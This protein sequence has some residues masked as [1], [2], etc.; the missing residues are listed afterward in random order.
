MFRDNQGHHQP[1][2]WIDW[3]FLPDEVLKWLEESWA[4]VFYREFFCRLDERPFAV[5]Y[6]SEPSRPNVPVNVLVSLEALKA[7]FGW[8]DA[9]MYAAFFFDL[10]V[11]YAVGFRN[12]SDGYFDLRTVYNFR[13][14]LC[15][16]MEAT[17]EDLMSK[18]FEGI[19]DQQIESFQLKTGKLRMDSTQIASNIRQMSRLQLLVE[20]VQRVY[21]MLTEA[22][23][24]RYA[25]QFA[26]YLKGSSGQYIYRIK[27]EET[28]PHLERIGELMAGCLTE[29]ASTYRDHPT[30]RILE[31]VFGEQFTVVEAEVR[32]KAGKE[33]SPS[34][35]QSPD[36]PDASY[37]TKGHRHYKGYVTNVSETC[38]PDNPFQLV[39]GVQTAPNTTE[40]ATM[41]VQAL[42][43]LK[44]RT[45]VDTMYSDASY[46]SPEV[47]E[48]LREQGVEQVP[49]AVKGVEK[50]PEA[51]HL[52]DFQFLENSHGEVIVITCPNGQT[53][54]VEI[55]QKPG[56][57]I[58]HFGA[59]QCAACP[60]QECCP[61]Q[62][63]KRDGG[64]TL[65]F[66][67]KQA[68][69]AQR[70]QRCE[71]HRKGGK[72]LR[73]AI[74]AVMGA[75]KRP[76]SDDQL[77]VRG[78]FRVSM[79]MIGSAA[80]V[81]VRRIQRHLAVEVRPI[82]AERAVRGAK[83]AKEA[84]ISLLSALLSHHFQHPR[85]RSLSCQAA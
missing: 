11:R 69:I 14:R 9:E 33:I 15:Q 81:N 45:G 68:D 12:L 27:G 65:K 48:V 67:E 28:G 61:T 84:A 43:E 35:L 50:D 10:Q 83:G 74:E 53:V 63:K 26:P 40:D 7:S 30:Y 47:D 29:L 70:R 52:D 23:R 8:S 75:I 78:L 22:D 6:S 77:P 24:E 80:M 3:G 54:P 73:V 46:C 18:A 13:R 76:F 82:G 44:E 60:F 41:L 42:P 64:R 25:E 51:L 5:L 39:T 19:T 31:R 1:P 34:S 72:N 56:R 55:G 58:A 36:D 57:C 37:R 38:D 2:L 20:V 4:G 71:A 79:M 17:G 59:A 49:T 62:V 16:H 66:S 85:W 32:A 21:R